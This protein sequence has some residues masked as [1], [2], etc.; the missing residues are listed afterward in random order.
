MRD[1]LGSNLNQNH[2]AA[3]RAVVLRFTCTRLYNFL[4][5]TSSIIKYA[6]DIQSD[7]L[8]P[9]TNTASTTDNLINKTYSAICWA[10]ISLA[11]LLNMHT[12]TKPAH[13]HKTQHTHTKTKLLQ[14]YSTQMWTFLD[15]TVKI[16]L[17]HEKNIKFLEHINHEERYNPWS[18][19]SI[20]QN[21]F[22]E[23]KFLDVSSCIRHFIHHSEHHLSAIKYRPPCP[24]PPKKRKQTHTRKSK[25]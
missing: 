11:F 8:R 23:F 9:A 17:Y 10:Q 1:R 13:P 5:H 4:R 7:P 6:L 15:I 3:W 21:V 2:I 24:H 19:K 16:S 12:H 22:C 14:T 20:T 18:K 25:T